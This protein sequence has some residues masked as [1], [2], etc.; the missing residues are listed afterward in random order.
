MHL[1]EA[2][3]DKFG[4]ITDRDS[5]EQVEV[6]G[7]TRELVEVIDRLRTD[8]LLC[9]CYGAQRHEIGCSTGGCRDCSTTGSTRAEAAA[10]VA[11]H[12]EVVQVGRLSALVVFHF[13]DYLVLVLRLFD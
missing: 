2:V 6:D 8:D 12:V 1:R 3:F 10:S 13:E 9:C 5:R 4:G 11:T 7:H